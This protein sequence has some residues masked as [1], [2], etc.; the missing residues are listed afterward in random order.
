MPTPFADRDAKLSRAVDRAFGEWFTFSARTAAA[1]VDMPK[2]ADATRPDFRAK[3]P[4]HAPTQ[5][6]YPH[7]RGALQDDNAQ[8]RAFTK[9]STSIDDAAMKWLPREGDTVRR[10]FDGAVYEISRALPDGFGRTIFLLT[11]RKR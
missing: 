9:P 6:G 8:G 5:S 2:V 1:D 4:F 7:A 10:E 11:A 3:G